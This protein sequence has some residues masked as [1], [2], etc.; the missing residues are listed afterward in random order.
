MNL[1]RV[2][3]NEL[4]MLEN[5]TDAAGIAEVGFRIRKATEY[6]QINR[7]S[8]ILDEALLSTPNF[9]QFRVYQT[10]T[11]FGTHASKN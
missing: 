11:D 1:E 5:L 3:T 7:T 8:R 6:F 4:E 10:F 2:F 9:S